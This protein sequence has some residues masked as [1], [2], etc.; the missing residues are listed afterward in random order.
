MKIR[1]KPVILTDDITGADLSAAEMPNKNGLMA[2]SVAVSLIS[3]CKCG[4]NDMPVL[5]KRQDV[6][7]ALLQTCPAQVRCLLH[8]ISS[9]V[10]S[11]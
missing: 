3:K 4:L 11:V 9:H 2:L 6:T 1:R 8:K 10:A 5:P 7:P